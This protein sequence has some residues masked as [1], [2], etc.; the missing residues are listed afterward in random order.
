MFWKEKWKIE[1]VQLWGDS[2]T[3]W[4]KAK[5]F[6]CYHC[7]FLVKMCCPFSAHNHVSKTDVEQSQYWELKICI[8]PHRNKDLL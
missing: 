1:T 8:E 2:H 7:N 5:G 3:G 6:G 4:N